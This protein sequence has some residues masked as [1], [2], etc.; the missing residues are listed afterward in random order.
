MDSVALRRSALAALE[1][2]VGEKDSILRALEA[3][4]GM[5]S[6]FPSPSRVVDDV[7]TRLKSGVG[8]GVCS[9]SQGEPW[10]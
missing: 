8:S 1:V 2:I 10:S 4:G 6:L 3:K 9:C 5:F 7:R